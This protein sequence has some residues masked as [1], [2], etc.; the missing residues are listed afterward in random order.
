VVFAIKD[1][2][3]LEKPVNCPPNMYDMM[4]KCWS[5]DAESRPTFGEILLQLKQWIRE[6]ENSAKNS[7]KNQENFY[8]S[9]EINESFYHTDNKEENV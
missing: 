8:W 2:Q 9:P 6:E 4:L 1:G 3:V 7:G 5:H